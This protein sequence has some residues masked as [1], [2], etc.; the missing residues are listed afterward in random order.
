MN[1]GWVKLWRKS[2][3]TGLIKNHNVWVFWTYCLMKANHEKDY[4]QVIG[5]QEI[6]LQPGQ[7]IFGL[8]VSSEETGL[9]IQKIRTCLSFLKK[10]KNLTIKST[11]KFSIISIINWHTYQSKIL[12]GNKQ[13]NKQV[14]SKQQASNNKQEPKNQR[15]KEYIIGEFK[16]SSFIPENYLI[17]ENHINYALSKKLNK[18]QAEDQFEAFLIYHKAKGSKFKSWNAAFQN[19]IRNSIKFGKV[20][21]IESDYNPPSQEQIDQQ[22]KDFLS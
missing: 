11:N 5:F 22:N 1:D 20:N 15:T 6:I 3:D 7:F 4:K 12:S 18:E 13:S 8:H 17:Q 9:S 10:Y 16:K 14:T 21:I 2:I 19:W